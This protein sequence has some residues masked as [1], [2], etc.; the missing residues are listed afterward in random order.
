MPR[1]DGGL[2]R[3]NN[4]QYYAGAQILYTSVAATTI[5]DFTF[6]TKLVLGS[7]TSYAP[8]DPDYTLNNFK[9]YT[10]PNGLSNWT[11]YITA[12]TVAYIED[13]YRTTSR[14]TLAA[15]AIGTYVKVQLKE[16]AVEDNYGGYKYIKLRE[17]VN[18]FIVGYV[19]QDKL[20]PRVNR[21]DV[22][23]HAKRGLQEF[24]YDTLKSIKSQELTIPDSL[25]L[26]IPQDY[27]NYVKLSWVDGNGVKHTIYPT[28]L[29]S[30]PWEAPVQA[31]DGEIV[32]DNFGDNIEG[33][34]Q[35]NE[36]W[37]KSNPSNITGLYPNDFTNPD[38][39]MY[40]WWGE[41]GGPFAW[42]GQRYGGEP[43]NMQ[44]NGWFNIDYKRGTFNFSS[45]LCKKLIILEYIS[46]GLA[47]DLDT[48]VP[49]LAEEA[50]YQHL[51]YSIMS[52]R[53][54]TA[55]IAPQYKKQRYAALRNA[56]IRLSN[57]KLDEIV[58]VMRNKSKW[59]KH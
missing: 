54:A 11:E 16:G 51:L 2:I 48:K 32:Q 39:F 59:I 56:K 44:M 13:G 1:P 26:T 40:D 3:E 38:L 6:N 33:T 49:K 35:I 27:V 12:Y 42:Y 52:T 15:Q 41:P 17:I 31:A 14:I 7:T 30:S 8:T 9:I 55:A 24:S 25:S 57:I 34:A 18:N 10:S 22:I 36:R 20:I 5:Y 23:F 53:T 4:F 29:T 37:Q 50:M 45:D 43:V 19:G 47:Y 21:T 28:Q 46:D 58:Q